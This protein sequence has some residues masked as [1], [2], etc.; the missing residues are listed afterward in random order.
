MK[1]SSSHDAKVHGEHRAWHGE[2]SS[3]LDDVAL[4][5]AELMRGMGQLARCEAILRMHE[6]ALREHKTALRRQEIAMAEHEAIVA[7]AQAAGAG[8]LADAREELHA[9]VQKSHGDHMAAHERIKKH[10][11]R[12]LAEIARLAK[13]LEEAM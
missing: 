13:V 5:Q 7:E 10:Q 3:M 8:D 2:N 11:H 6:A 4:W 12:V 9:R 1:R